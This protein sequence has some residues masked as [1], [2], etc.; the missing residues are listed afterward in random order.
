MAQVFSSSNYRQLFL[1]VELISSGLPEK[2]VTWLPDIISGE[3]IPWDYRKVW[4][5]L[6]AVWGDVNWWW[7]RITGNIGNAITRNNSGR[8]NLGQLPENS[9]I[10][11]LWLPEK[12]FDELIW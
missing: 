11:N 3:I 7:T 8:I 9:V 2:S 4:P 6:S 1:F 12:M 5:G 10:G